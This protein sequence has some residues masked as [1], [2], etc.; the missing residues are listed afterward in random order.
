MLDIGDQRLIICV[1]V[2]RAWSMISKVQSVN[3][4]LRSCLISSKQTF[5]IGKK[6]LTNGT[7]QVPKKKNSPTRNLP[8][9]DR[10]SKLLYVP[11]LAINPCNTITGGNSLSPFSSFA[12]NFKYWSGTE[13]DDVLAKSIMD[14]DRFDVASTPLAR[15]VAT[16]ESLRVPILPETMIT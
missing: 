1:F 9:S 5:V 16:L 6:P 14:S 4:P 15:V 2:V 8:K 10:L 3:I 13:L 11:E 12:E 7:A